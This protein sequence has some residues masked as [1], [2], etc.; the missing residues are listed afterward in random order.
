MIKAA[1]WLI[2]A[3]KNNLMV[4]DRTGAVP[5]QMQAVCGRSPCQ[6]PIGEKCSGAEVGSP[7]ASLTATFHWSTRIIILIRKDEASSANGLQM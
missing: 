3:I 6:I 4:N 5:R 1:L 7:S 2:L